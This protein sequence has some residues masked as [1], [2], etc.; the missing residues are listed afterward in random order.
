V[1]H[2]HEDLRLHQCDAGRVAQQEG[3]RKV[4]QLVLMTWCPRCTHSKPALLWLWGDG[5]PSCL[6]SAESGVDAVQLRNVKPSS[7]TDLYSYLAGF[8][9]SSEHGH[10]CG[11]LFEC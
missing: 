11:F 9:L 1:V 5:A 3:I 2:L 8:F 10:I 6:V 4:K 7:V